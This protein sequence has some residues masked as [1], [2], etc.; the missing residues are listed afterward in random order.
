MRNLEQY[1]VT[2]DEVIDCLRQFKD[3]V[4]PTVT[5]IIGD[6]RPI[7]LDYAISALRYRQL[8]LWQRGE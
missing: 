6:M 2:L 3:E 4:D 8:H 7:L 5:G 1:P